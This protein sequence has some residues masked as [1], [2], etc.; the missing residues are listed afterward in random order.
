MSLMSDIKLKDE[1]WKKILEFLRGCRQVYVGSARACRGF[2][3]GVLW[4]SRSGAQ[5]RLLPKKYG[6]W[7]SV[8]KRFGRWCDQGVWEQM[9]Q[10]FASD[11]DLENV[12]VDSTVSRAHPC[13]A[14][15]QKRLGQAAQALGRSRGGFSTKVH[16]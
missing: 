3:E 16:A 9:H 10:H 7:N 1:Q 14:G 13:A 4:V 15:R 5:W 8:Y 12:L 6:K 11:P 2:V